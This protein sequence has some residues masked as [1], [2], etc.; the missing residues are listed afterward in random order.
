MQHCIQLM[1]SLH[2]SHTA[3]QLT[4]Q[5]HVPAIKACRQTA[6][7]LQVCQVVWCVIQA[8]DKE[9]VGEGSVSERADASWS[10]QE[11]SHYLVCVVEADTQHPSSSSQD[12]LGS[13]AA[14]ANVEIGVVAVEI[15]TG[16]VLYGQ[17]RCRTLATSYYPLHRKRAICNLF[18]KQSHGM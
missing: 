16:D 7:A 15:S 1:E 6:Q 3:L 2:C 13:Q 12:A 14:Q 8:G 11:L 18:K 4:G 17:F 9:H 10:N 5:Q